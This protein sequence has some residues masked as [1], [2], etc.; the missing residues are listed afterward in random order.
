[1]PPQEKPES[2]WPFAT[3]RL[4]EASRLRLAAGAPAEAAELAVWATELDP[5]NARAWEMAGVAL[6]ASRRSSQALSSL[7][8][9][10]SLD[11]SAPSAHNALGLELLARGLADEAIDAFRAALRLAPKW[12]VPA[13]NMGLAEQRRG[14]PRA[15]LVAF[16]V[17]V[18]LAPGRAEP[19]NALGTAYQMLRLPAAAAEAYRRAIQIEPGFAAALSNLGRAHRDLG[20]LDE[21]ARIYDAAVA[22]SPDF[23]GAR[24]NRAILN[25][26]RGRL[27]EA[28]DDHEWRWRVPGFPS[29]PRG[30]CQPLWNGEEIAGRRILLH[31]EQGFGDTLQFIRYAPLVA[32]LGAEVILEVPSELARLISSVQGASSVVVRGDA[33]PSFDVQAPLLSLPRAFDTCLETIPA[34]VPYLAPDAAARSR[35]SKRL[36]P[37]GAGPRVGIVWAGRPTHQN[38]ANRSLRLADMAV[39]LGL[40]GLRFYSLQVGTRAEDLKSIPPAGVVDLSPCLNDFAET[41]AALERLDLLVAVDTSVVHLAGA[42][43]RPVWTLL[44]FSPDWRWMTSREDSPWYPTMRLFRQ[45]GPGDWSAPLAAVERELR[46]LAG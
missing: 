4:C 35:W 17:A 7:R 18:N 30:F 28:W 40:P 10:V 36:P 1:M 42:L 31:A 41:G 16:D 32:A 38:D 37:D 14:S 2:S 24:W 33:L 22:A 39:L 13:F 45:A 27:R 21:A 6:Q 9:S 20:D 25:L 46:V 19:W 15:A 12:W 26:L 5:G 44:P 34:A 8:Q 23:P 43:A 11:A 3:E 29:V